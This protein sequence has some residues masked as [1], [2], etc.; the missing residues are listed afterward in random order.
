MR[1][2]AITS[3]R[4]LLGVGLFVVLA[5]CTAGPGGCSP[6]DDG[7]GTTTT[8]TPGETTTTTEPGATST[9]VVGEGSTTTTQ[10][11]ATT[12]TL[13][14]GGEGELVGIS[15]VEVEDCLVPGTDD[16]LLAEATVVACDE[17]HQ[18]EVFAQFVLDRDALP[19]SGDDYPGGNELTWYAQDEC[20]ARFDAY[21]GHSYW[22]S[23]FDLRTL[24][25]SFSTWDAGDRVITCL[26][27]SGDGG[28]L[29]ASA[30]G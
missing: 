28:P 21:T 19:G 9:T 27:V 29:T 1:T 22:T 13:P 4:R 17:P 6:F 10:P 11:G 18:M 5:G 25:P 7:S 8:T 20:Q 3:A 24:T 16:A 12:T 26:I 15:E 23:P 30:K 14:G 2:R